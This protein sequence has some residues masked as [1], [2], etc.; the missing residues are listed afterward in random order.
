M[1]VNEKRVE[2]YFTVEA[3]MVMPLVFFVYIIAIWLLLYIYE[4]CIWEQNGCRMLVWKSY[5]D[6][7]VQVQEGADGKEASE[8]EICRYI[9]TKSKEEEVG[10]YI[11]GTGVETEYYIRGGYRS[12]MRSI[13]YS[14]RSD[15]KKAFSVSMVELWPTD[16]IRRMRKI[17]NEISKEERKE[18]DK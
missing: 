10:K 13:R 11:L 5:L 9:L 15:I 7:Y 3:A 8:E 6:G 12:V 17:E 14:I 1:K 16:Y 18:D 4:S 2:A